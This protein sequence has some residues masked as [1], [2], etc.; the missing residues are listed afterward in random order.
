M[1]FTTNILRLAFL[2]M[3]IVLAVGCE[4]R[5]VSQSY[6]GSS[7]GLTPSATR[8]EKPPA[9]EKKKDDWDMLAPFKAVG[10]GIG[11]IMPDDKNDKLQISQPHGMTQKLPR[12]YTGSTTFRD[13]DGKLYDLEYKDGSLTNV[14]PA[15]PKDTKAKP[16][17]GK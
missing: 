5:V 8:F 2:T 17:G 14:Q 6:H 15:K 10:D 7:T 16:D 13:A 4:K 12:N 9:P 11:S 1:P 3:P